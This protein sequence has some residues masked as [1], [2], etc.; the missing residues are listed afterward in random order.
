M[1]QPRAIALQ[2]E[3]GSDRRELPQL[4]EV[5]FCLYPKQTLSVLIFNL[6]VW[7]PARRGK[8]IRSSKWQKKRL[9][10]CW[11]GTGLRLFQLDAVI[12][13]RPRYRYLICMAGMRRVELRWGKRGGLLGI[14]QE[15]KQASKPQQK[16]QTWP[17]VKHNSL[18]THQAACGVIA[19][20]A[21][22]CIAL[23]SEH[24]ARKQASSQR[25]Y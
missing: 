12:I 23:N 1:S 16:P 14:R 25:E 19:P 9:R 18:V 15:G 11:W 8:Q 21:L 3:P 5:R 17:Q 24:T 2:G 7:L 10:G 4:R 20:I 13:S 22:D 6:P